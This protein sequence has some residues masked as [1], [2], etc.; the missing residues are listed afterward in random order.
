MK[1]NVTVMSP[2]EIGGAVP[3]RSAVPAPGLSQVEG[4][5]RR[6]VLRVLQVENA[7]LRDQVVNLSLEIQELKEKPSLAEKTIGNLFALDS[8]QRRSGPKRSSW[9][10]PGGMMPPDTG[11][12]LL[13]DGD[14]P[15][16]WS[17]F[18]TMIDVFAAKTLKRNLVLPESPILM[19]L[20]RREHVLAWS[21]AI[22]FFSK[23]MNVPRASS[24]RDLFSAS[25]ACLVSR[26]WLFRPGFIKQQIGNYSSKP[27]IFLAQIRN[28]L[29]R[30]IQMSQ[31]LSVSGIF[32]WFA[33]SLAPSMKSH[34]ANTECFADRRLRL[35]TRGH[36]ASTTQGRAYFSA[37]MPFH[38]NV[39]SGLQ[40]FST[41]YSGAR[42]LQTSSTENQLLQSNDNSPQ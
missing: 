38:W 41:I 32:G 17:S 15:R 4:S 34:D 30:I 22:R 37:A 2:V 31:I 29:L 7:R 28:L 11:S 8:Y 5:D 21:P 19:A 42:M 20:K 1:A 12:I 9:S 33:E 6:F 3:A 10:C 35:A 13:S 40:I 23:D 16:M 18:D 14:R 36:I 39:W 27:P 24:T 25:C 26:D